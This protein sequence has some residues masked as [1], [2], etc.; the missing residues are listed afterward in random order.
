MV[1]LP[2][3]DAPKRLKL[4]FLVQLLGLQG[5]ESNLQDSQI[6]AAYEHLSASPLEVGYSKLVEEGRTVLLHAAVDGCR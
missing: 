3:P 1:D 6:I 2:S 5:R 4:K